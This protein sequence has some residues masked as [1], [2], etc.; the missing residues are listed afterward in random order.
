MIAFIARVGHIIE[1]KKD[2]GEM[3]YAFVLKEPIE[4]TFYEKY[5][6]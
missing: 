3:S 5:T 6:M 4:T 1:Y 2:D